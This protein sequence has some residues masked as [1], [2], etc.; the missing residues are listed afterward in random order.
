MKQLLFLM[1]VFVSCRKKDV[2]TKVKLQ[3]VIPSDFLGVWKATD[4]TEEGAKIEISKVGEEYKVIYTHKAERPKL[5][6]I[7]VTYLTHFEP[8]SGDPYRLRLK[9]IDKINRLYV[10][11]D[12]I[13]MSNFLDQITNLSTPGF[14]QK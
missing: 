8:T 1:L 4:K 2:S 10:I 5:D 13:R 11:F 3:K 12:H 6:L 7:P 14:F 9:T